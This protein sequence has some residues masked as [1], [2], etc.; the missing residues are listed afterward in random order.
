MT[1]WPQWCVRQP[2]P[3]GNYAC[4][5]IHAPT[6][7]EALELT[8]EIAGPLGGWRTDVE[9]EVFARGEYAARHRARDFTA[10]VI[11]PRDEGGT[12]AA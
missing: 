9:A 12:A 5:W 11:R 8:H 7:E 2:A 10:L 6:A 3:G 1:D 4:V